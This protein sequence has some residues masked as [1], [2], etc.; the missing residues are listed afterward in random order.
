MPVQPSRRERKRIGLTHVVHVTRQVRPLAG[1]FFVYISP[2]SHYHV[3]MNQ[4]YQVTFF[5]RTWHRFCAMFY[6]QYR[7]FNE[8]ELAQAKALADARATIE[9]LERSLAAAQQEVKVKQSQIE[10]FEIEVA[11]LTKIVAMHEARWEAEAS[12]HAARGTKE[13]LLR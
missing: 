8:F 13:K 10:C 4:E 7:A 12:V 11:G 9:T 2:Q 6:P 1:F 5:Q 3:G